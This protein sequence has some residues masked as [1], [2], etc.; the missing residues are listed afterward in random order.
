MSRDTDRNLAHILAVSIGAVVF[1]TLL[2]LVRTQWSALESIDRGA[3]TDANDLV[4]P[5]PAVVA[6]LKAVTW[7]GSDGVLWVVVGA[8]VLV[9]LIRRLFPLAAFLAV[10]GV[11]AIVLDPTLKAL[12]GRIRPVV[13]HPVSHGTG[14]SFPSGH[15]LGSI[16]CYGALLLVFLPAVPARFRRAVLAATVTLV[17]A[18]GLTRIMLSVH[19]VS[20]VIGAWAL[21]VAW[22]GLTSYAFDLSRRHAGQRTT[23]PVREG[24]EPEAAERLRLAERAHPS[25][26]GRTAAAIVV[27]WTLVVGA[28]VG[29]G[30]LM[31]Y[32]VP[33]NTLGDES[34]PH[35]FATHR[36][37]ALTSWSSV[38]STLGATE[39]IL[40]VSIAT[41]TVAIAWTR[42][43][44][45]VVFVAILMVG[46]LAMFLIAAAVV[47]RPRPDVTQLDKH[48]PTHAYPS[49]HIAA[50]C[51]IYVAIAI[52]V[53]GR[54]HGSWRWIALVPA[55]VMPILV[56]ASRLYRG[57]HHPTDVLGS[58]IFAAIW[59]PVIYRLVQPNERRDDG[60]PPSAPQ[61]AVDA[62]RVAA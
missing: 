30:E 62:G 54:A 37:S 33:R 27:V 10:S 26:P 36:S 6:V 12:V 40:I 42:S 35:W 60:P 38:M 14:N 58:L 53:I 29:F 34:V 18:I 51:C 44:R 57:E 11:G 19:Y 48:L 59:V 17:V 47:K 9:L 5:H 32:Y 46:E 41:C 50:T 16:V 4:A 23:Q 7:L 24:I 31:T 2:L 22:L 28:V 43:W 25:H 3:A 39:W 52:L 61:E 13:G 20:D 21:G 8:G 49:G 56:A 45:P 55:I 1:T 15:S